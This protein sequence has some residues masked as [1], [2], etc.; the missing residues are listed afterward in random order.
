MDKLME[1]AMILKDLNTIL[2]GETPAA[3]TWIDASRAAGVDVKPQMSLKELLGAVDNQL[4]TE[5]R[6]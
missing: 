4:Q 1:L 5:L 2:G 3:A 6:R